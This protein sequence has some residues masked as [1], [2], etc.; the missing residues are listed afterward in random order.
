VS[1]AAALLAGA[2]VALCDV[3]WTLA[4]A[5]SASGGVWFAVATLA[6]YLPCALLVGVLGGVVWGG[7]AATFPGLSTRSLLDRLRSDEALDRTV[8]AGILAAVAAATLYALTV[9][10]LAMRLVAGTQRKSVGALLLGG[11]A[12]A[13]VPLFVLAAVPLYAFL[14][15]LAVAIPRLG[16]L[17]ATLL[18]VIGS[19]ACSV[20]AALAIVFLKLDWRVLDLGPTSLAL[21]F[22]CLA[23]VL[24]F[25]HARLPGK[26]AL[27]AIGVTFAVLAPMLV[28]TSSPQSRAVALLCA[29]AHGARALCALARRLL[30]ADGDGYAARL[31]GGDCDDTDATVH[32]G[33][34]ELPDNG[35]DDNCLGGDAAKTIGPAAPTA[36]PAP[37]ALRWDG[38]VLLIAVDTLRADRLG[39]AGYLV[40]KGKTLTPRMDELA[41]QGVYFPQVYAQ[42]PNT[43]RSFPSI[44]T[45]RFPSH[46]AWDKSFQNYP[47]VLPENVSLFEALQE[48]GFHTIGI[49]SH[50]YFTEERGIRQ[51]FD[52]FDNEGATSLKDS[53]HD[54][55]APRITTKVTT[56]LRGLAQTGEKFALF[57]HLFEPHS[58][59]MV[60]D[61]FPITSTGTA[62]LEEKYDYE[63]AFVDRYV[64]VILDALE[65]TGLD[66]KTMVVLF[67]DHGEA[68]GAH[69]IG[70]QRLFFHGQTLYDELL[71]VPLIVKVPG[72][73]AHTVDQ[74]VMLVDLAPTLLDLLAKGPPE[75]FEGT[76]LAPA[77]AGKAQPAHAAYGELLAAPS[78]DHEAK[79]RV[80][81]SGK[82]KLV[83]RISDNLF[84][85]YDL[86]VDPNEQHD[87]A[88]ANPDR[89]SQN[90]TDLAAWIELAPTRP[91]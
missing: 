41:R 90:K 44:F 56:R 81:P 54:I 51:G 10:L 74:P 67:S 14:R 6:L 55:A 53:N 64:G 28:L 73:A 76:S 25:H 20:A 3:A 7:L 5:A 40:R 72:I 36:A 70:G 43:P 71:R 8:A 1:I 13:L 80:D 33:A 38:N 47:V 85:L 21:L 75:S 69:R 63:I 52:E 17:P 84:E 60:H 65:E 86:A 83:Y 89:L 45:S 23:L 50:F 49:A 2:W 34:P 62:G 59:Y 82:T 88:H 78:W 79:M 11:L 39:A 29:D 30:D 66:S 9:A 68:F 57:A 42:A 31:D 87:L 32:P 37:P 18:L 4:T 15:R 26:K 22:F 19:L 91:R 48:Q 61:D 24:G 35:K 12:A 58:T 27:L 16:R 77:L 46:I